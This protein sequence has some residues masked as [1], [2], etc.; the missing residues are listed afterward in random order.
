MFPTQTVYKIVKIATKYCFC[1][2]NDVLCSCRRFRRSS[3]KVIKGG[4]HCKEAEY[5]EDQSFDIL[6]FLLTS[7]T[8]TSFPAARVLKW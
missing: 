8:T 2:L 7:K 5:L 3:K 1:S 6:G 4:I